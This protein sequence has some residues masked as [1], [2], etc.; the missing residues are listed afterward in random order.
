MHTQEPATLAE[1]PIHIWRVFSVSQEIDDIVK[2][3][4][5][6]ICLLYQRV[7]MQNASVVGWLRSAH[8]ITLIEFMGRTWV[9]WCAGWAVFGG[10]EGGKR[11]KGKGRRHVL[12]AHMGAYVKFNKYGR[13]YHVLFQAEAM[14][15]ILG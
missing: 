12:N 10:G 2:I 14:R 15:G 8:T 1:S 7:R 13:A 6:R 3:K 11:E 4:D 5:M 9:K